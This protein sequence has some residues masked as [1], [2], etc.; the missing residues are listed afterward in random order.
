MRLPSPKP[1]LIHSKFLTALQGPGGKMS[2]SNP[3]S[4]IFM[5]DTP[6]QIKKKINSHA[7]SGGQETLELHR[8]LGGNPDVDVAYVG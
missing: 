6:N 4:A 5:N 8:E 2:A 7:F 1:A 3:N